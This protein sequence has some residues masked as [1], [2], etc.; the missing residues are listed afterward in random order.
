MSETAKWK[1]ECS[2]LYFTGF[3]LLGAVISG[4]GPFI[5]FK[6]QAINA[7][8][9]DFGVVF[10]FRGVGYVL[11]S[12][13]VGEIGDRYQPH[14]LLAVSFLLVG[15]TSFLAVYTE[16]V[17]PT[18]VVFFFSAV[19]CAGIDVLSQSSI[20]EV[21]GS[22]VDPW[23][24]FLHFCFG[25]GSFISPLI[26]ATIGSNAYIA[27][28]LVSL[29]MI[30]P[31]FC[32]PSP[33]IHKNLED[34]QEEN[35]LQDIPSGLH[36]VI[37]LAFLVY[38]GMEVGYGGWISTYG[39][40]TEI[41]TKEQAAYSSSI[42]WGAISLGRVIAVPFAV[43]YPTSLQLRTLIYLSVIS[44]LIAGLLILT[45]MKWLTVF[46]CSALFGLALSAIYPLL[47]SMPTYLGFKLTAKKTSN[48]V[49]AGAIG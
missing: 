22:K 24:Q 10:T 34:K 38:V 19:G 14:H 31:S 28:G 40:I 5:P 41:G 49:V 26:L 18:A 45:G 44:M 17:L 1:W 27:L 6:A 42:F 13:G 11:A 36:K 47:M 20:V 4:L 2:L 35:T 37:A 15:V 32:F 43:R 48:Y 33:V 30:V 39:T 8:E 46:G 21:H 12:L 3:T 23:M 25:L 16:A 9:T 29:L 7:K